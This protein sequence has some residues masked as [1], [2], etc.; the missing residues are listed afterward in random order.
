MIKFT[1]GKKEYF[2][3]DDDKIIGMNEMDSD[4]FKMTVNIELALPQNQFIS[5]LNVIESMGY[6]ILEQDIEYTE[7]EEKKLCIAY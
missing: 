4:I 3:T 2:W 6:T 1:D 7:K 5:S